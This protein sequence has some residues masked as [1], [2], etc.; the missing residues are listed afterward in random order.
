MYL[1]THKFHNYTL[2]KLF[3]EDSSNRFIM[4]FITTEPFVIDGM[5]LLR[6]TVQGQS[7]MI[8]QIRKM[9]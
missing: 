8:H 7:F 2:K 3:H 1:G 5:E 9:I 6:M 4:K